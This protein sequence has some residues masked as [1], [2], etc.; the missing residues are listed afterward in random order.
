MA[1]YV[2]GDIQGCFEP[3]QRLL[4]KV[5]FDPHAD[6]LWCVG[7]LVNR[8]PDSLEVLR[9]LKG[10]GDAC[11]CVLGNHD[12]TLLSMYANKRIHRT[13]KGLARVLMAHDAKELIDWLRY[14]PLMHRDKKRKVMMVH[15]GLH[16]AWELKKA[17]KRARRVEEQL[18][19]PGWEEF[20]RQLRKLRSSRTE[21][22]DKGV[23]RDIFSAA[24]LTRTRYCT[25]EGKF[26]WRVSSG[27]PTSRLEKPWFAHASLAWR[28]D[29]RIIYG[30]WAA[31]GVVDD[32]PHVLGLDSGCVWGGKLTIA[33]LG[34]KKTK[35]I[36]VSCKACRAVGKD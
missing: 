18:R 33:R 14:R 26:N 27:G 29:Y 21:P 28:K 1:V 30:H 34:K 2:V 23:A 9:Y 25:Q 35:L 3:L 11:I 22:A 12:L 13:D 7:D 16:P 6:Q 19:G 20:A 24:V 36:S 31:K 4:A 15:A 10:L 17:R 8:G 32:Q 5:K